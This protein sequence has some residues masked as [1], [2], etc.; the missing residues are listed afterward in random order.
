M[1]P[2]LQRILETGEEGSAILSRGLALLHLVSFASGISMRELSEQSGIPLATTYRVVGQLVAAGF[3]V[4]HEGLIHAG[5]RMAPAGTNETPHLVEFARPSL[6]MAAMKSGLTA[7][8]TVRVHTLALCL[9]VAASRGAQSA[10]FRI[11]ETR[12]LYAGASATPLLAFAKP[13]VINRVLA[14]SLKRY[15]A[16]TPDEAT[17]REKLERVR[18][19]GYD[20]T[21][22]EVQPLWTGIGL[23]VLQN[24]EPICCLSLVGPSSGIRETEPYLALLREAAAELA[25]SLPGGDRPHLWNPTDLSTEDH[26]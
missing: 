2:Q 12:P 18:A 11:G 6:H 9:D 21:R 22:G 8:L 20:I 16:Q 17:L 13:D 24:N 7:V 3:V 14:G 10:S 5:T 15:T 19:V 23:P 1:D 26:S 25:A 4:E